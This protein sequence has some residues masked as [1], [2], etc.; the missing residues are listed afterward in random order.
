M[1]R[2]A[3]MEKGVKY[4]KNIPMVLHLRYSIGAN[5]DYPRPAFTKVWE[6]LA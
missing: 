4:F 6:W 1:D 5:G 3:E 2:D